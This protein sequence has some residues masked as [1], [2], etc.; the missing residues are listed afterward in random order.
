MTQQKSRQQVV[1]EHDAPTAIGSLNGNLD[2][3][4]SRGLGIDVVQYWK[5]NQ[6]PQEHNPLP[7]KIKVKDLPGLI[8]DDLTDAAN[9]GE[10]PQELGR[11]IS[12]LEEN[13]L[14]DQGTV[15]MLRFHQR[16]LTGHP[17]ADRDQ[18]DT[19]K[20]VVFSLNPKEAK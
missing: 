20:A 15:E 10:L 14:A 4:S 3:P 8:A 1:N 9:K 5:R 11:H 6:H 12:L 16:E 17:A 19:I 2:Y 7:V 13:K 18:L